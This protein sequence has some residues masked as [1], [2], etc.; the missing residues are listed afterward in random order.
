MICV[1]GTFLTVRCIPSFIERLTLTWPGRTHLVGPSPRQRN[2]L[3]RLLLTSQRK[4]QLSRPRHG[5]CCVSMHLF[6][7]DPARKQNR[8]HRPGRLLH[9]PHVCILRTSHRAPSLHRPQERPPRPLLDGFSG[10]C[11]QRYFSAADNIL[12]HHVLL[13]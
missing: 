11:C 7:R 4:A 10:I 5:P 1:L 8:I 9:H 6:R 2:A 12:Q 3:L 13:P